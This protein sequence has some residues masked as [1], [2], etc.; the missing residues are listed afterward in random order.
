M[1]QTSFEPSGVNVKAVVRIAGV[2]MTLLAEHHRICLVKSSCSGAN[3]KQK[4][5]WACATHH[6][7]HPLAALG[8]KGGAG[9]TGTRAESQ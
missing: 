1:P 4:S 2:S 5:L 8:V 7:R 9:I 6:L 3:Q